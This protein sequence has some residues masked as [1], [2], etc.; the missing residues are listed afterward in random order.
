M[1]FYTGNLYQTVSIIADGPGGATGNVKISANVNLKF[2]DA[3]SVVY[4][5]DG[6]VQNTAYTGDYAMGNSVHWIGNV[7]T[8]A[9][10]LDQLAER[11]YNIENP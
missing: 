11:I 10:A 1:T 2:V 9:A 7:T 8:I 4:F 6:T 5:G 3:N